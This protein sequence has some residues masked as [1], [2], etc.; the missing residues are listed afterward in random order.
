MQPAF[1]L[2]SYP[3]HDCSRMM[4]PLRQTFGLP[5]SLPVPLSFPPPQRPGP[6]PGD[7]FGACG[8]PPYFFLYSAAPALKLSAVPFP[9]PTS[10]V[11][12]GKGVPCPPSSRPPQRVPEPL[13]C[14]RVADGPQCILF[15]FVAPPL[16]MVFFLCLLQGGLATAV[17]DLIAAPL[18]RFPTGGA[19]GY[20]FIPILFDT[21][22]R[23]WQV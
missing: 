3:P 22:H 10:T 18:L 19:A 8:C 12:T 20:T 4:G 13:V 2:P 23:H 9:A 17:V 11:H 7:T 15:F 6:W 21:L 14:C 1:S 5:C 16:C